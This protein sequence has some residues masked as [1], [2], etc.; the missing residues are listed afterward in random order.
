MKPAPCPPKAGAI[1]KAF[2]ERSPL[3]H[4]LDTEYARRG[5]VVGVSAIVKSL[6]QRY[7]PWDRNSKSVMKDLRRDYPDPNRGTR[8]RA[9]A[10]ARTGSE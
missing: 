2:S 10:A 5:G 8:K 7:G 9:R 1:H 3:Y 4:A 6:K